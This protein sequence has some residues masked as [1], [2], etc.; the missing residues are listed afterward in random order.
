MNGHNKVVK[1][2]FAALVGAGVTLTATPGLAMKVKMEKCYGVAK[3]KQND[4]GT[5]VHSCAG[6]ATK[7][8]DPKEWKFVPTGTCKALQ[9][10]V[11]AL[12]AKKDS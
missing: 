6:Q 12:E 2:A 8:Y 9:E 3:A 1:V 10:K 7:D 4:C 5:A 11:A